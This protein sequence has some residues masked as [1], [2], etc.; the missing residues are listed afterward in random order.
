ME[1][2]IFELKS[3]VGCLT[4]TPA[5]FVSL[6]SLTAAYEAL[7]LE[8]GIQDLVEIVTNSPS[9]Q[10]RMYGHYHNIYIYI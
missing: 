4:S 9:S 7:K 10:A 8:D 1:K 5:E 3:S 6:D 2:F